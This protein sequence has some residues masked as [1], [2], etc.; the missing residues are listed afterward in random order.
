MGETPGKARFFR[1]RS[2]PAR[3]PESPVLAR[4]HRLPDLTCPECLDIHARRPQ[5]APRRRK[6]DCCQTC[7]DSARFLDS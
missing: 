2:R 1:P 4:R 5:G 6:T 7:S 3:A